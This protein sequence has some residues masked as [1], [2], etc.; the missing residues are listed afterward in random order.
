[1]AYAN[2]QLPAYGVFSTSVSRGLLL[3]RGGFGE[4][5]EGTVVENNDVV[6]VKVIQFEKKHIEK[7]RLTKYYHAW[8]RAWQRNVDMTPLCDERQAESL[9][10]V[11]QRLDMTTT[12]LFPGA[13][14]RLRWVF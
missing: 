1:M 3:G 7:G 13:E 4:V 8:L 11:S 14:V 10:K 9:L 2:K 5:Y 12:M 6:A